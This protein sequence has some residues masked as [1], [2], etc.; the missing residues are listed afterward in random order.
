MKRKII[1]RSENQLNDYFKNNTL[2]LDK[3]SSLSFESNLKLGSNIIFSG[4][5]ILG[6]NN[7][8]E[9]NCHLKNVN[10]GHKNHIKLS[11]IINN[12][13]LSNNIIIGPF[14]YIRDNTSIDNNSII[15]AYVE[16]TR[17]MICQKVYA[18]H[19]AFIG[20]A[21]IGSST[22]IGAGVVFCNYNFIKKNKE[23]TIIEKNCKIGANSTLI[24]PCKI[25]ANTIIPALTKYKQ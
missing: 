22:I 14:A 19:R 13:K 16:V 10:V 9:S 25:K 6:K 3:N 23:K 8:V 24:A 4:K 1:L 2:K 11:S 7:I 15:G 12:S 18:S 5:V 21:K 20:D 17:S